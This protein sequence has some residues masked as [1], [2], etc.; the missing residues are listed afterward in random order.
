MDAVQ[1]R[2]EQRAEMY[3]TYFEG[4]AQFLTDVMRHLG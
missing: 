4:V 2:N 1:G 3:L